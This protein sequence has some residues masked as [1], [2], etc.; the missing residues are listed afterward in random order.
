M[1]FRVPFVNYP[2]HYEKIKTEIDREVGRI[3][4]TGNLILRK[5]VDDFEKRMADF[6]GVPYAV[7]VSSGTDGLILALKAAGIG[8]GDEVITVAHTFLASIASIAHVG[9]TPILVDV[10][11]DFTMNP[12]LVEAA[13]T[14][15]TKAI[16]P[17]HFNG[18]LTRMDKIKALAEKYN[19]KI[20]E[21]SCQGLGASYKGITGGAWGVAAAFSF[22]PAKIL[23]AA[24]DAGLVSTH[25]QEVYETVRLYRDHGRKTKDL[26]EFFGYTNRIDNLQAAILNVKLNYLPQ[27]IERRREIAQIYIKGLSS[28]SELKLPYFDGENH[29]DTFQNFVVRISN[30]DEFAGYLRD[31]G[32]EILVSNPLPNHKQPKLGLTHF[33]L[34][35]TERLSGEVISLPMYPELT[36]DQV[37]YVVETI[38]KYLLKTPAL[39]LQDKA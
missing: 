9:A 32:I 30:R 3:L 31:N 13:I 22:Y 37:N 4:S 18:R 25:S 29:H 34:P 1:S 28:M 26:F 6:I 16:M 19:L 24:G 11:D 2:L 36:D 12:D 21:D 14:K 7:G 5:D 8:A 17:V 33:S 10:L 15:N 35:M 20:I 23:G 38:G 27:W 39:A